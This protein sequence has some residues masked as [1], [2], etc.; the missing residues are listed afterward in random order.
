MTFHDDVHADFENASHQAADHLL[1]WLQT[2]APVRR[3]H[4][5][6]ELVALAE[7][8]N[9]PRHKDEQGITLLRRKP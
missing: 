7:D 4:L 2:I 6:Q 1:L 8:M 9:W 5:I 3:P